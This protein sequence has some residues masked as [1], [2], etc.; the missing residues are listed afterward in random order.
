MLTGE[1]G[2]SVTII[3]GDETGVVATAHAYMPHNAYSP[4]SGYAWG[5]LVAVAEAQRSKGL[6]KLVNALLIERVFR[7]LGASHVY[8]LVSATNIPSRRMVE[9]CGLRLEPTLTCGIAT[10]HESARFTK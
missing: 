9:A 6:G 3:I 5:G 2:R 4:Y 7:D 1:I 10:P 8:E